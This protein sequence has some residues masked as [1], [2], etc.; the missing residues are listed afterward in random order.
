MFEARPEKK[1][2]GGLVRLLGIWKDNGASQMAPAKKPK[3]AWSGMTSNRIINSHARS[4]PC[5]LQGEGIS[6]LA[7]SDK[8]SSWDAFLSHCLGVEFLLGMKLLTA[9]AGKRNNPQK[10]RVGDEQLAEWLRALSGQDHPEL[11]S[12]GKSSQIQQQ[13]MLLYVEPL[14][15]FLC[16]DGPANNLLLST[17]FQLLTAVHPARKKTQPDRNTK[18]STH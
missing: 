18:F 4:C 3:R 8:T 16:T 5:D 6:V 10:H 13:N 17:C 11:I 2:V 15:S 7:G 9:M 14:T 12:K 1:Q